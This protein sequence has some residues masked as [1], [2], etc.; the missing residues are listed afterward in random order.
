MARGISNADILLQSRRVMEEGKPTLY[1]D[2]LR[3]IRPG[4]WRLALKARQTC[5]CSAIT[6][7]DRM[8]YHKCTTAILG[9]NKVASATQTG[10]K[11]RISGTLKVFDVHRTPYIEGRSEQKEARLGY[12]LAGWKKSY[13]CRPFVRKKFVI[14]FA[15]FLQQPSTLTKKRCR[16]TQGDE[17]ARIDPDGRFHVI[18]LC[19]RETGEEQASG[20]FLYIPSDISWC[21]G[22]T[23]FSPGRTFG[24]SQHEPD[25]G[26]SK[27][28]QRV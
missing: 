9:L 5:S 10:P 6:Q 8:L 26:D 14:R 11:G 2:V 3:S 12:L 17:K 1:T 18:L 24:L 7:L 4:V 22:V 23:S 20:N 21:M 13:P 15:I 27:S 25:T 19:K 28:K 16:S